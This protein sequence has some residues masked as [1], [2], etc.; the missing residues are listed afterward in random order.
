M[1]L[2]KIT[3][4]LM[5]KASKLD[6]KSRKETILRVITE[7]VEEDPVAVIE[8]IMAMPELKLK[9]SQID[10]LEQTMAAFRSQLGRGYL[11]G[12]GDTVEAGT[13]ITITNTAG[14]KKRISS[15][16]G[17][18][19]VTTPTGLVNGVNVTYTV[20]AIPLW[21]VAD[22]Q[23]YFENFGYTRSGLTITMDAAPFN[24][25]RTIN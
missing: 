13:N 10:G 22:N 16:G 6:K 4:D 23:T 5:Q 1:N 17:G 15:T 12:G 8:K 19:S 24:F 14:G 7:K 21:V 3:T 11:H 25:I 20:A 18:G 2:K 9:A